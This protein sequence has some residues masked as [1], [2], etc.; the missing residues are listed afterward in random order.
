MILLD[1]DH[2]SVLQ[3]CDSPHADALRSRLQAVPR[4]DLGTTAV[5]L[6][7]QTRGWLARIALHKDV[8]DQ[9]PYY[10]RLVSLCGFY[11]DWIVQPFDA[12]AADEFLRL[13]REGVR[14]GTMDLK[15]AAIALI[16]NATLL[17]ANLKD[18]QQVPGLHVEDWLTPIR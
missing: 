4:D 11:A 5:S 12:L 2:L 8:R 13:R 9:V 1:T 18:F 14:I 3:H 10:A 16:E 7:E 17:S 6:E 15:I